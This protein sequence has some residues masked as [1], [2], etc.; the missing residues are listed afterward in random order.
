MR[1]W[2]ARCIYSVVDVF[3]CL[4]HESYVICLGGSVVANSFAWELVRTFLEA[5]FGGAERHRRRLAK[6]AELESLEA[7]T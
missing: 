4:I 3:A 6:I 1:L 7:R 2:Q 5:R